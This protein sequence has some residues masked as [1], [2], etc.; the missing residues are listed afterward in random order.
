GVSPSVVHHPDMIQGM[1][2]LQH[3]QFTLIKLHGDYLDTRLLNTGPE[4]AAY[5]PR[6]SALLDRVLGE[7]GLIVCGW[8]AD[9]DTALRDA[10]ARTTTFRYSTFWMAHSEPSPLALDLITHRAAV[11]VPI[12]SADAAFEALWERVDALEAGKQADPL[13]PRVVLATTKRFL[14]APE[15]T[16][17]RL[18]ELL[19]G[20]AK[21]AARETG[22]ERL[23]VTGPEPTREAV[24]GHAERIESSM[25]PLLPAL[26][27]TAR[28]GVPSTASLLA[29]ALSVLYRRTVEIGVHTPAWAAM[30]R[31]P[32]ALALYAI[33]VTAVDA[34]NVP[35][36]REVLTK[37]KVP[38]PPHMQKT[39]P[40]VAVCAASMS[41]EHDSA[42][43]LMPPL[44]GARQT[45]ASERFDA[46]LW[47]RLG[48]MFDSPAVWQRSFDRFEM[49]VS[50][51]TA[52]EGGPIATG[53]FLWRQEDGGESLEEFLDEV[54]HLGSDHITLNLGAFKG[55]EDV[56][57]CAAQ[58][59][60]LRR[61]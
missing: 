14:S 4:L 39:V 59:Q 46:V 48:E 7:Y 49:I 35:L 55:M 9:W 12:G 16:S 38:K 6:V 3:S 36:L 28:W 13:T 42:Q 34:G 5:D 20:Q 22:P 52:K 50:L 40:L 30:S 47:A 24:I 21:A 43:Q 15:P 45:P 60:R 8:S 23:P 32:A 17:L 58:V 10:I 61:P 37:L 29:R 57:G 56:R 1:T 51:L 44:S 27:A 11:R 18:E 26:S 31:Y 19:L 33:G 2:P 53:A 25:A 41:L 54:N